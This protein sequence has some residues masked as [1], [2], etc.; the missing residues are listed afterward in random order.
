ME[1]EQLEIP[2]IEKFDNQFE[3][4]AIKFNKLKH[5]YFKNFIKKW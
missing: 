1:L 3:V 2:E 5:N 4:D